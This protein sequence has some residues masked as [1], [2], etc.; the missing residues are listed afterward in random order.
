VILAA[1]EKWGDRCPEFLL[2]EFAFA[3]WDP[4]RRRLFCA[5]DHTGL[6]PFFYWYTGSML[7]FSSDPLNL[8]AI[9]GIRRELNRTKLGTFA[10]AF[11][12]DDGHPHE[13]FFRGIFSLPSATA[14]SFDGVGLNTRRY[15]DPEETLVQVPARPE[16]AFEALRELLFEAVDCRIRTKETTAVFLSGG[17]DSS[18]LTAI[19]ARCLARTNRSLT[20]LAAVLPESSK[21]RFT[22]E[23]EF[24]EEFRTYPNLNI[25]YVAPETGGPF[26]GIEDASEFAAGPVVHPAGYLLDALHHAA[27]G[28]SAQVVLWGT[29][30]EAGPTAPA[31]E[32]YLEL[33]LG[34]RWA[35]LT[36]ELR[37]FRARYRVK[38]TRFLGKLARDL[39][40]PD[41]IGA[42][43]R[44]FLFA[45]DFLRQAEDI[46]LQRVRWPDHRTEQRRVIDGIRNVHAL[47]YRTTAHR[48]PV[49]YPFL[50]KRVL[51]FCL[52][53]PGHLKVRNGYQRYLIRGALS[54]ILPEKIQWRT[55]KRVFAPDYPVRFRAQQENALRLIASI[56]ARDPVR[57]IVDVDGL[58]RLLQR[59]LSADREKS[60]REVP[61]TIY[62]IC[63]LRQFSEFRP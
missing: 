11:F 42:S 37:Q 57:G 33:A 5:R 19:A 36:R 61:F 43:P 16:E 7:A 58:V 31:R 32:Y 38:P 18:A 28:R 41:G 8:F 35:T 51:E 48:A 39:L 54:G 34:M 14:L 9:P 21:P 59:D 47:P 49:A 22:D 15:W 17:L 30:G 2:G 24:V 6:R 4:N 45:P 55:G 46:P 29:G 13:T 62:L 40:Y 63:F 10:A 27:L 53:A 44:M 20:A 52:A 12:R 60:L 56:G 3:V 1:Y 23:R 50:D 25:E 26:D